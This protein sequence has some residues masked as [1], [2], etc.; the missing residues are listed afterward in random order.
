MSID[1]KKMPRLG[2]GMM[3]LPEIDG[4]IDHKAVCEMVD[5]YMSA[6]FNYFDTAYIYHGGRSETEIR[7]AVVRRYPRSDFM[8]T[9]K[10]PVW[11]LRS[12]ADRD[13][14]FLEQLER[15][16]VEYFDI[17]LLH[18]LEEGTNYDNAVKYNCFDWLRRQKDLGRAKHIGFSFHG[19][20]E[21]LDRI[22]T[23][24][25]EIETVQIQLN[26]LDWVSPVVQ[27]S[28]TYEVLRKHDVPIL[29]MEPVKGG[30]LANLPENAAA[31]LKAERPGASMASW[32]LRFVGS[33]P[34]VMTLLSGMST[35]E[36]MSD[37]LHTFADFEPLSDAEQAAVEKVRGILV[38]GNTV[39]C[40]ACRYCCDGCP[41]GINIPE[42]FKVLNDIRM[43]GINDRARGYYGNFAGH[44]AKAGDCLACGQCESVCPQHLKIIDLLKEASG[45]LDGGA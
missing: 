32:A 11:M 3:R 21:L 14:I 30:T 45:I 39:Q 7:E 37:N 25:P 41:S 35:R 18:S 43:N 10:L 19:T 22:L 28:R 40:T 27:A 42:V 15:C 17:V 2:F 36:Q 20:P 33:L 31:V 5:A 38:S 29:V 6:G 12:E 26:Y 9:D 16:G 1:V 8:L 13:R 34:G 4:S 24:H 44:D 23:E